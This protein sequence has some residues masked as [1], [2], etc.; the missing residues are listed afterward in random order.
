VDG[1]ERRLFELAPDP[2]VV[3]ALDGSVLRANPAAA[4]LV[5][6]SV[7]EFEASSFWDHIHPADKAAVAAAQELV[8][9]RR[10]GDPPVPFRCRIVAADGT[11]RWI[12]STTRLDPLTEAMFS[13]IR[14]VTPHEDSDLEQLA[15][16]FENAPLG[17]AVMGTGG[18][19]RRVNQTLERMLGTPAAAPR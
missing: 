6:R 18:A 3:S 2:L 8:I 7:E 10:E 17:M 15:P 12:E 19:L 13:V 1:L 5:G 9:R 14:D 4:A 16:L 11:C